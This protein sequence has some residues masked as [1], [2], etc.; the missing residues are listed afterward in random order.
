M[1][2]LVISSEQ[3]RIN[4]SSASSTFLSCPLYMILQKSLRSSPFS[5]AFLSILPTFLL[6]FLSH[7]TQKAL[8]LIDELPSAKSASTLDCRNK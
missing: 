1:M 2:F 5:P 7:F 8:A 6:R 4:I 3:S